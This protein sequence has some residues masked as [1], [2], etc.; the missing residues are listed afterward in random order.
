MMNLAPFDVDNTTV[1]KSG[2]K[3]YFCTKNFGDVLDTVK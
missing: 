2:L 3:W 1:V